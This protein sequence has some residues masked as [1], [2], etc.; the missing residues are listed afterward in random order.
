MAV[1][2]LDYLVNAEPNIKIFHETILQEV[3][4]LEGQLFA[5]SDDMLSSNEPR[6]KTVELFRFTLNVLA[7]HM[8]ILHEHIESPICKDRVGH[9]YDHI[10]E[11]AL[12]LD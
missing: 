6:V 5:I 1:M 3:N 10:Q 8:E 2:R 7:N 11:I 9:A 12:T 4:F